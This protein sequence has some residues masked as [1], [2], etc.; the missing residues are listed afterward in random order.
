MSKN[1]NKNLLENDR[2]EKQEKY[3]GTEGVP[4]FA[5][6]L[7]LKAL[8]LVDE[9]KI[10]CTKSSIDS[11]EVAQVLVSPWIGLSIRHCLRVSSTAFARAEA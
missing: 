8:N 4:D 11:K 3:Q 7:V 1:R 9:P 10:C 6:V 5:K 2:L